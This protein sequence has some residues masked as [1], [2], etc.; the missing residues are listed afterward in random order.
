MRAPFALALSCLLLAPAAAAQDEPAPD[1]SAAPPQ[2]EEPSAE[3]Q[4]APAPQD[5]AA[6]QAS[7][8]APAPAAADPAEPAEEPEAT[9]P[10]APQGVPLEAL[11][12]QV[13]R[14]VSSGRVGAGL[15]VD[16]STVLTTLDVVGVGRPVRVE[17]RDRD[18]ARGAIERWDSDWGLALVHLDAPL[19]EST[20]PTFAPGLPAPGDRVVL[21]GHGGSTGRSIE[22]L[23]LQLAL[24]FSPLWAHVSTLPLAPEYRTDDAGHAWP[25]DVLLDRR[26]GRGDEGAPVFDEAGQVL[27]LVRGSVNGGAARAA[28]IPA[29][30]LQALLDSVVTEKP[31][32]RRH[33]L[34]SW[35][36]LGFALHN[37]PSHVGGF[38]TYGLRVVLFDSLR[39][40]PWVEALLGTRAAHDEPTYRPRD[41]WWSMD[42]GLSLGWRL[43]VHVEGSRDYVVPTAGLRVGWNRFQHS[44]DELVSSCSDGDPCR[45]L[46][47]HEVDQQK[48][49]R[50]GAD[51]GFDVRHGPLRI[52]YRFFLSPAD[53]AGHAMHRLVVT[54]D[55]LGIPVK[56]GDSN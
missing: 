31:Y 33:H 42:L 39:I 54:F 40:E 17:S 34:Q 37:R 45:W 19:P 18:P 13:V 8:E 21:I 6:P 46:I 43:P 38:A 15:L 48:D 32:R 5:T 7:E 14:V 20:Q 44:A 36:G 26:V 53:I 9:S 4:E 30:Q 28:M 47:A 3:P 50:I 35:G 56:L 1:S 52:G 27:G 25:Q 55:G 16:A 49:L 41:L 23:E 22:E 10:S 2:T 24:E 12:T 29:E 11:A 51:L